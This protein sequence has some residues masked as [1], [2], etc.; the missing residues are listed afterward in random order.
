[1]LAEFTSIYA[2]PGTSLAF[3]IRCA[4]PA[5]AVA[6]EVWHTWFRKNI[7]SLVMLT[8]IRCG[9][10]ACAVADEVWHTWFPKNI[11]N[12]IMLTLI[13]LLSGLVCFYIFYKSI[14]FFEKI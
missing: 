11:K 2:N 4:T 10:L 1:L 13:L 6:D 9:T 14:D 8:T 5:C 12:S 3:P 7:K